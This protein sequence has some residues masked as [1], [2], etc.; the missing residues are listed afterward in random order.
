MN[1]IRTRGRA[2]P[3]MA[4]LAAL[5][6]TLASP[7]IA[8]DGD[9]DIDLR[10][11]AGYR[12]D[13]NVSLADLDAN[14]GAAD[15]A[16]ILELSLDARL[17][18]SERLAVTL[19]YGLDHTG[20]QDFGEFDTTL[21]RLQGDLAFRS[22]P[23]D[24]GIALRHFAARLDGERFLD[25]RQFS[26]YGGRLFGQRLYLRAAATFS[27]RSFAD[28]GE[29]DADGRAFDVDAYWLLDGM[30]RYLA[31][32]LQLADEDAASDALDFDG[33][34]LRLTWGQAFGHVELKARAHYEERDY[35]PGSEPDV[36]ARRDERLRAGLALGVPLGERFTLEGGAAW[37]GNAST[38][39]EDAF[40]ETILELSLAAEF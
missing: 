9:A 38:V 15:G 18:V 21:H 4:L 35:A 3:C 13:S 16:A 36:A 14:L 39:A 40:A 2:L 26:P 34:R 32:G 20:W 22:G 1:T 7:A 8:A 23:W 29:R 12:Y 33:R 30:Q 24:A 19:G 6:A 37:A 17:P 27:D 10:A 5:I 11:A 25:L 28:R 31:V